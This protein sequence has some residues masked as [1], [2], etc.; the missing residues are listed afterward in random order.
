M[1][2]A[3]EMILG[4][5]FAGFQLSKPDE[6]A[7]DYYH[8]TGK[9]P[10]WWGQANRF[11]CPIGPEAGRGFILMKAADYAT[12]I[13]GTAYNL[14]L[15]S[16]AT[17]FTATGLFVVSAREALSGSPLDDANVY[18]VEIAD[19]RS[20]LTRIPVDFDAA[21]IN[22]RAP[23][24]AKTDVLQTYYTDSR[25]PT[26]PADY[27]WLT[28]AEKLWNQV[29]AGRIG[30]FPGLPD[31]V[32]DAHES[33]P[34]G[35]DFRPVKYAWSALNI[36][37][38]EIGCTTRWTPASDAIDIIEIGAADDALTAARTANPRWV[39]DPDIEIGVRVMVPETVR[40]AFPKVAK[41]RG[42]EIDL[43]PDADQYIAEDSTWNIDEAVGIANVETGSMIVISDGLSA[44][45]PQPAASDPDNLTDLEDRAEERRIDYK[46]MLTDGNA[47]AQNRR[48]TT[49]SG[50][51]AAFVP[52]PRAK[53]VSWGDVGGGSATKVITGPGLIAAVDADGRMRTFPFQIP[54]YQGQSFPVWPDTD[55]HLRVSLLD[56][57]GADGD[58]VF[59]TAAG[60][61]AAELVVWNPDTAAWVVLQ[62]CWWRPGTRFAN[63]IPRRGRVFLGRLYG[64]LSDDT[65][66]VRPLFVGDHL[67]YEIQM[68]TL[69]AA[70]AGA[71][72][73]KW[74]YAAT[75]DDG[76]AITGALNG[77]EAPNV[78]ADNTT[79]QGNGSVCG[80]AV[81][82]TSGTIAVVMRAVMPDTR[83]SFQLKDNAGAA[84]W[85]FSSSN[86]IAVN[87]A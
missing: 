48:E 73:T 55:H 45:V 33:V 40:V 39:S 23:A 32:V 59:P 84:K 17:P 21:R 13:Q 25:N 61:F 15:K 57:T 81:P 31:G 60:N 4:E 2:T 28:G 10:D 69:G 37:L 26:G 7:A 18:L 82:I 50:Y 53:V 35:F 11:T 74:T 6:V 56:Y 44:V 20:T 68:G 49:Y 36:Y 71:V 87:C 9:T 64:T 30:A 65:D 85:E 75:L 19:R 34:E 62:K 67:G 22:V 70:S 8:A 63:A 43:S 27:T 79:V 47:D 58:P 14:I 76:S 66:K 38:L 83:H 41:H 3:R 78:A 42:T 54:D 29:G 86:G 24:G 16:G 12:L 46:R 51:L 52:G 72:D 1:A 5:T 80:P 77:T